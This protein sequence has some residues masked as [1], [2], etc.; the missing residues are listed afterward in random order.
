M[1]VLPAARGRGIAGGLTVLLVQRAKDAGCRR[2][3]LHSSDMA[4]GVYRRVGF[5]EQCRLPFPA[6]TAIWSHE[7]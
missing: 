6:T 1:S 7:R 4:Q 2:V 5:V 3:L